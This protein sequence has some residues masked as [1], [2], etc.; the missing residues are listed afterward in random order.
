MD[1]SKKKIKTMNR[2]MTTNSKLSTAEPKK[3][4]KQLSKQVEQEQNHR[5]GNHM[6]GYQWG[7]RRG[8]C[9]KKAQG[10]RSIIGRHKIDRGTS[11]IV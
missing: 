9:G 2:K 1:L 7:G 11:R 6:E 4:Q 8:E 5:N 3:S 10:I